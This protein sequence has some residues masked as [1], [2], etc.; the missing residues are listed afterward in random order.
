MVS[1]LININF[2]EKTIL[3]VFSESKQKERCYEFCAELCKDE[4]ASLFSLCVFS[5]FHPKFIFQATF[6]LLFLYILK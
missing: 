6:F 3:Y 2:I 1:I 5:F 4:T